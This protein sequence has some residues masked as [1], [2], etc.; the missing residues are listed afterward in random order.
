MPLIMKR[1]K[2]DD[3]SFLLEF[4]L[5]HYASQTA[6]NIN[7]ELDKG[8]TYNRAVQRLFKKFYRWY[9]NL[10]DQ[11]GRAC[12]SVIDEQHLKILVE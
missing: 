11:E 10:K 4:K 3:F 9:E 8:S 5:G 12:P 7:R 2:S 6:D 1:K